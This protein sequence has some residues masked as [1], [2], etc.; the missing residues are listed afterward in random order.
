MTREKIYCLSLF[1]RKGKRGVKKCEESERKKGREK[2]SER[3][4]KER[5]KKGANK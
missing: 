3:K 4:R 2:K 1:T 5:G